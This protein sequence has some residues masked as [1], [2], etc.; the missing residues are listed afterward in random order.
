MTAKILA[1]LLAAVA[2]TGVG[3]YAATGSVPGVE[4][5]AGVI[6]GPAPSGGCGMKSS[7]CP[8]AAASSCDTQQAVTASEPVAAVA[9]TLSFASTATTPVAAKSLGC[10]SDAD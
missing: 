6:S 8:L 3:I 2:L 10:C 9:G 1:G 4:T 7:G 5:V